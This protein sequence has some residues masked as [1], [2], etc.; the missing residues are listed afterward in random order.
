[1]GYDHSRLNRGSRD[2]LIKLLDYRKDQPGDI[3]KQERAFLAARRTQIEPFTGEGKEVV[4]TAVRISTPYSCYALPVITA[5]E[6]VFAYFNAKGS[7]NRIV[8]PFT[9]RS[10]RYSPPR[11]LYRK[12]KRVHY[13]RLAAR[14]LQVHNTARCGSTALK[15]RVIVPGGPQKRH[16]EPFVITLRTA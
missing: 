4:V 14:G 13:R 15:D 16:P 5:G 1:M 3:G 8:T 11:F 2:F 6:K 9:T 10:A 7:I 12:P